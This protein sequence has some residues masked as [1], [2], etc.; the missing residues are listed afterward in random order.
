MFRIAASAAVGLGL[1]VT[2]GALAVPD[3]GAPSV[4]QDDSCADGESTFT[5]DTLR[6]LRSFG[7]SMAVVE[8]VKEEVSSPP[9]GPE[10][11]LSGVW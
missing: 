10:D 3:H 2:G 8:A 9:D 6:D 11:R 5:E 4:R 1:L 7:D